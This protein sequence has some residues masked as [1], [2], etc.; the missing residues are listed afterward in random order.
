M[1]K[2][3]EQCRHPKIDCDHA[4]PGG[5]CRRSRDHLTCTYRDPATTAPPDVQPGADHIGSGS[6]TTYPGPGRSYSPHSSGLELSETGQVQ[7]ARTWATG[8]LATAPSN[9]HGETAVQS[10]DSST[11][12]GPGAGS[13]ANDKIH[14]LA[15]TE[16]PSFF[17]IA[18][19]F[20]GECPTFA[21]RMSHFKP[22]TFTLII[23]GRG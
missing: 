2:S 16:L 12:S 13:K 19:Y 8:D 22:L 18:R 15:V 17:L 4:H 11:P 7:A 20:G 9:G 3:C 10:P 5:P 21:A 14:R 6:N 23:R 1:A